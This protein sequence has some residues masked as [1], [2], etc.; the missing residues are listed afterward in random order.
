MIGQVYAILT[1]LVTPVL[2]DQFGFSIEYTSHF[3]IAVSA[4]FMVGSVFQWVTCCDML[5]TYVCLKYLY[6]FI[7]YIF[8]EEQY[9]RGW[10]C[11]H[12]LFIMGLHMFLLLEAHSLPDIYFIAAYS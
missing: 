11:N 5:W 8:F 2:S 4:A 9:D 1:T 12:K 7:H 6:A 10:A 3:L